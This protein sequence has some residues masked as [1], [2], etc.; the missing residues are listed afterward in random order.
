MPNML[1][2]FIQIETNILFRFLFF[3]FP[4]DN[5]K[6]SLQD[7][8]FQTIRIRKFYW[9]SDVTHSKIP[10]KTKKSPSKLISGSTISSNFTWRSRP[11][12]I[13]YML[14]LMPSLNLTCFL[15]HFISEVIM[16]YT[17]YLPL[18]KKFT[19]TY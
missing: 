16:I 5:Y 15:F 18:K 19:K 11:G 12:Y 9:V 10:I 7:S 14:E 4:L 17:Q 13:R 1:L 8:D 6:D 2:L 3:F